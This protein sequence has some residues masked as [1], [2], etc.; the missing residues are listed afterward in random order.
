MKKTFALLLCLMMLCFCA[1]MAEEAAPERTVAA[2]EYAVS[3]EGAYVENLI[4]NADV[5]ISGENTQIVFSNCEFNGDVI[6]TSEQG[7]KVLLFGCDV[8][9]TC[10][11]ANE[12]TGVD[13]NYSNPKFMTDAPVKVVSETGVISVVAI[14]DFAFELNGETY[15]MASADLFSDASGFVPYEGQQADYCIVGQYYE[16]GERAVIVLNEKE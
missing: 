8:N 2:Y 11:A 14:G 10:I 15:S 9:G 16:N 4:F 13:L 1:A 5:V 3:E 6:L 7:T 12:V